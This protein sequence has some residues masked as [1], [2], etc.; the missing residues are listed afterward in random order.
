VPLH[1]Q[2]PLWKTFPRKE[3]KNNYPSKR[4]PGMSKPKN[5]SVKSQGGDPFTRWLVIGM[6]TLVVVV[7]AVFSLTSENKAKDAAFTALDSFQSLGAVPASVDSAAGDGIVFNPGLP[8]KIDIFEDFQCPVCKMF[9]EPIGGYLTSLITEKKAQ[10]T[11]H[12][13]SFLGNGREDDESIAASNAAYCAV[14]EDKFLDFHK[15]LMDVQSQ[16][17]NSGFLNSENLITIG[18]KI[19]ITSSTFADCVTNKSKLINVVA[20]TE[21]MNRYGVRGTPTTL[22]NGKVWERQSP[23]FDLNEFRA[24]V[25]AA[26]K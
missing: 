5:N 11:Y 10:V 6:V 18:K 17:E 3:A 25:E 20:A 1:F 26:A 4:G 13:L 15:A 2:V 23:G 24:A 14:D 9:E 19:G 7:G 16:V 21:S 8:T 12:P 22:I